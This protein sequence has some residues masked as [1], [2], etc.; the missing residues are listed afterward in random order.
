MKLR[1]VFP[2]LSLRHKNV[3]AQDF[4]Q[5]PSFFLYRH[6]KERAPWKRQNIESFTQIKQAST[7][8]VSLLL[9]KCYPLSSFLVK[10][11]EPLSNMI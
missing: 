10:L 11:F 7:I 2:F 3:S 1:C 9:N 4:K 5:D 6:M 8:C